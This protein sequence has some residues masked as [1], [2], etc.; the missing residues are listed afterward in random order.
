MIYANLENRGTPGVFQDVL[1]RTMI[2]NGLHPVAIPQ[3]PDSSKLIW[4]P[5]INPLPSVTE[6]QH[7]QPNPVEIL[8][9]Q[10]ASVAVN[11]TQP[12]SEELATPGPTEDEAALQET[13]QLPKH[14]TTKPPTAK[15]APKKSFPQS[16]PVSTSS[17][18]PNPSH[19]K[20]ATPPSPPSPAPFPSRSISP[21]PNKRKALPLGT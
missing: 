15:S 10:P 20:E 16:A 2:A 18:N 6:E 11:H 8:D 19:A 4:L 12:P 17:L 21:F 13:T 1:S 5:E 3:T 14:E 9:P 7:P